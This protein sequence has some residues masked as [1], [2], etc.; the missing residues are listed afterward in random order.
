[1]AKYHIPKGVFLWYCAPD[2][3]LTHW[4]EE[5]V[6]IPMI[7]FIEG[8]MTLPMGR[9][10]KD[11]LIAYRLCPHQCVPK[12]FKVL[13]SV[14]ALNE[15]MGLRLTSTT[16]YICM[17]AIC[18]LTRGI[19]LSLGPQSLDFYYVFPIASRKWHDGLH[20]PTWEGELGGVP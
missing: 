10:T 18:L 20:Y 15:Q 9:V 12:L 19:T 6:V 11:Y 2:Q 1:M 13:G 5:E 3:V 17:N 7:A 4:N 8:G 16:S 14:D